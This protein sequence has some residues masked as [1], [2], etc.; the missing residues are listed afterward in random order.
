M[1]FSPGVNASLLVSLTGSDSATVTE[2]ALVELL[3]SE[4]IVGSVEPQG[5]GDFLVHVTRLPSAEFVVRVK[6]QNNAVT[7]GNFQ[8]QTSTRFRSSNLTI[9]VSTQCR[10]SETTELFHYEQ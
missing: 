1:F 4:E 8:R 2:V 7:N 6:G 9:S 5:D 3:R 10:P